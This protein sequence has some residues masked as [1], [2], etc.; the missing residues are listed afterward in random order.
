[1]S[2]DKI[3][4]AEIREDAQTLMRKVHDRV[5]RSLRQLHEGGEVNLE[6][7]DR[8]VDIMCESINA[9]PMPEAEKLRPRL[10]S[11][12]SEIDLLGDALRKQRDLVKGQLNKLNSQQKASSAYANASRTK[13]ADAA[14]KQDE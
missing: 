4:H 7:L 5:D 6:G 11:L 9:M 2:D 13:P 12:A 14:K 10:D 3:P 1:M 8:Q